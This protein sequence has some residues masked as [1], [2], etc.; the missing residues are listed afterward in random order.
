MSAPVTR[1]PRPAAGTATFPLPVP[2]S[3][4]S[5]P[6][7]TPARSISASATGWMVLAMLGQSPVDHIL[8]WPARTCSASIVMHRL[9][10][11]AAPVRNAALQ[12]GWQP[13]NRTSV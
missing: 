6:S 5:W 11:R 3:S 13:L 2:T 12:A 9:Y 4:T 8:R 7:L 1:A 10:C